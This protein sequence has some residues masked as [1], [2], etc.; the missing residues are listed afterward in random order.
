LE[1]FYIN[2][3]FDQFDRGTIVLV[4]WTINEDL[5]LVTEDGKYH[6]IDIFHYNASNDRSI[7]LS[8][9]II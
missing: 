5:L 2:R 7:T 8:E 1:F 6:I 3:N 4:D 9:V